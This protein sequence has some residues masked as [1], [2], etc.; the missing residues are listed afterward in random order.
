LN[1]PKWPLKN[2]PTEA[3]LKATTAKIPPRLSGVLPN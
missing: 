1:R 2:N 3:G